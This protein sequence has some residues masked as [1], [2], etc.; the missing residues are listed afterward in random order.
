MYARWNAFNVDT[1]TAG[2]V[3]PMN[4]DYA[5]ENISSLAGRNDQTATSEMVEGQGQ[6]RVLCQSV[7]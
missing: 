7:W 3:W 2:T 5:C 1:G 4:A 6:F